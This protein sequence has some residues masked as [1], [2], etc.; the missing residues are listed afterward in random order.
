MG[1]LKKQS[2]SVDPYYIPPDIKSWLSIIETSSEPPSNIVEN[3]IEEGSIS[4]F[5]GRA[6]EGKSL[7][8]AQLSID[9]SEGEPFLG[10]LKTK[11][12]T[13]LYIDY[14]NRDHKLK[15]RGLDLGKDRKLDNVYFVTYEKIFERDLGLDGKNLDHLAEV[16]EQVSP[17]LLVIDPLRLATGGDLSESWKVISMLNKLSQLLQGKNSNTGI[18]LVHHLVKTSND[19]TVKLR[20]DPR[21]WIEKTFGS[22]ALIAHVETII[23]LERDG[24]GLYTLATVPR[25]SEPITWSLEKAIQSERFVLCEDAEQIKT[26]PPA[27]QKGYAELPQDFSWTEGAAIV[28]NSTL[29]RIIRKAKPLGLIQQDP[30]T[31]RYNK[32]G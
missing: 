13:V 12:G 26:W 17:K 10:K 6:K 28:G 23:G 8:A 19:F 14:E 29:D 22:Q 1:S 30:K 7:L 18:L 24:D 9:V 20:H 11:K 31:K 2:N 21:S 25:S 15:I 4:L 16:I 3:L 5:V 32:V 27:L